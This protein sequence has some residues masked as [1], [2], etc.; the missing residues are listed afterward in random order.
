MNIILASFLFFNLGWWGGI[1]LTETM[2][3]TSLLKHGVTDQM[4]T[5]NYKCETKWSHE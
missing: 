5:D 4:F 3:E 1:I 2:N